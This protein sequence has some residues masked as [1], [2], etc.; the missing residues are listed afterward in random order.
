MNENL[1]DMLTEAM[2]KRDDPTASTAPAVD[3]SKKP[4]TKAKVK[5]SKSRLTG[6]VFGS[7]VGFNL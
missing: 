7:N 1:L 4:R 6:K 5:L 3:D 2:D